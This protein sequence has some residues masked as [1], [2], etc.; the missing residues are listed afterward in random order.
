[1][2]KIISIFF[3]LLV[4]GCSSQAIDNNGA[5]V[6]KNLVRYENG[7]YGVDSIITNDALESYKTKYLKSSNNKAFAQS[8]SGAWSWKSNRTSKDHAKSSALIGCQNNNRKVEDL[9]PC[10]IINI[11]GKWME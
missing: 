3:I 8:V 9:Y 5:Q 10:K 4:S 7:D 2:E 1:M 11:N 6:S